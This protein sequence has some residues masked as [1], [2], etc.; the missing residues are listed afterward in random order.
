MDVVQ[1]FGFFL[2][3]SALTFLCFTILNRNSYVAFIISVMGC[4]LDKQYIMLV[5]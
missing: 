4:L 5:Q 1:Y 2:S 3:D